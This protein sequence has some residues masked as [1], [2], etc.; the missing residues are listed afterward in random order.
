VSNEYLESA[1][2][3]AQHPTRATT[4]HPADALLR[5]GGW[6]V[7]SRPPHGPALWRKGGVV[8]AEEDALERCLGEGDEP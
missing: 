3:V 8:L 6:H 4:G 1:Y 7:V 2:D 5:L